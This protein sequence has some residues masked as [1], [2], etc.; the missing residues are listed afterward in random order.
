MIEKFIEPEQ[1]MEPSMMLSETDRTF[2]L[3]NLYRMGINRYKKFF[4]STTEFHGPYIKDDTYEAVSIRVED[5]EVLTEWGLSI[6]ANVKIILGHSPG[7]L[8]DDVELLDYAC[9]FALVQELDDGSQNVLNYL[10]LRRFVVD[11]KNFDLIQGPKTQE[12][13]MEAQRA[14][15]DMMGSQVEMIHFIEERILN[16]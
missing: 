14:L 1:S 12:H 3:K 16:D 6:D 13:G 15:L 8:K 2:L 4:E 11:D 9:E 7:L 5:A 10:P